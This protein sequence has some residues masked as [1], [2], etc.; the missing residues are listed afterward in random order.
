[1]FS[2]SVS[3]GRSWWETVVFSVK[4]E[5]TATASVHPDRAIHVRMD[6]LRTDPEP[7]PV[8][9]VRVSTAVFL[10]F[11]PRYTALFHSFHKTRVQC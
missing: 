5:P 8:V 9:H 6:S 3:R 10:T 7:Y 4:R 1:M 2:R 11:L